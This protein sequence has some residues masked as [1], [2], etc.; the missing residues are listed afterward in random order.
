MGL[1]D[2]LGQD[3]AVAKK[4]SFNGYSGRLCLDGLAYE[5]RTLYPLTTLLLL[6][7]FFQ[8]AVE[9]LLLYEDSKRRTGM[10]LSS[11]SVR[12]LMGVVMGA[13]AA[14]ISLAGCQK[15]DSDMSALS[16]QIAELRSRVDTQAHQ[17]DMDRQALLQHEMVVSRFEYTEFDPTQVRYFSLNNGVVSLIGQ[18]VQV[19]PLPDGRGSALTLRVANNGSVALF[20]PGFIAQWGDAMPMANKATPEQMQQWRKALHSSEFRGQLQLAPGNWTE[21]TLSLDGV[22]PEQLHYLRL[23]MLMDQVAF[24]GALIA[25]P[26]DT[27]GHAPAQGNVPAHR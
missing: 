8:A 7:D 19:K 20:N 27:Q 16:T 21:I 2:A 24:G 11:K 5:R 14:A 10:M 26:A 13:G 6:S 22:L 25:A 17:I 1:Y 4:A 9:M 15:T 18:L 23:T 3:D 12:A